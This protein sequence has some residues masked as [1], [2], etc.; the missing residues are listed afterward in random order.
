MTTK[1]PQKT[2]ILVHG[3]NLHAYQWKTIAWGKPPMEMGRVT[4]GIFVALYE[5]ADVLAFG[6]GASEKNG[7]LEADAT[8]QLMWERFDGI[9]EFDVFKRYFPQITDQDY[10]NKVR[11]K[12]ESI[13]EI[14]N[15]SQNTVDEVKKVGEIFNR[16]GVERVILVSSPT[17]LPRCLRDACVAF[18][19]NV[20]LAHF[21]HWLS[22]VPSDTNY[23]GK[24]ASDVAVFEPPHRP[25]RPM[26]NINEFLKRV[27]DIPGKDRLVFLRSFDELLQDFDV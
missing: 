22:A 7:K 1:T 18:E 4:K 25:D 9:A 13:L 14:E 3:C 16:Y 23:M 8:V 20:D 11:K 17:H 24:S 27:D 26:F 21:R 19:Q 10:R 5:S 6:T 15:Q 2:G 12:I